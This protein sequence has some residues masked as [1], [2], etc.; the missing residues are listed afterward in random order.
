LRED[1]LCLELFGISALPY[2]EFALPGYW[3]VVFVF[4]LYRC[5]V[6]ILGSFSFCIYVLYVVDV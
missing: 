6:L 1:T 5:L 2:F 3:G 4:S